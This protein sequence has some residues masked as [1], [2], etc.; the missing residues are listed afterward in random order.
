MQNT[1]LEFNKQAINLE[2]I[3]LQEEKLSKILNALR[4]NTNIFNSCEDYFEFINL[5]SNQNLDGYWDNPHEIRRT[6]TLE[7]LS[8]ACIIVIIQNQKLDES[9]TLHLKNILYN[10][11]QNFL[12]ILNLLLNRLDKKNFDSNV[13]AAKLKSEII[14][15]RVKIDSNDETFLTE[16]NKIITNQITKLIAKKFKGNEGDNI[17][18]YSVLIGILK[19]IDV[20]PVSTVKNILTNL[21]GSLHHF[22]MTNRG[23]VGNQPVQTPYLPPIENKTY[24]L[25]LDLDETLVH[26]VNVSIP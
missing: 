2:E 17:Q 15:K 26:Y 23:N 8:V 1:N 11:H 16:N 7:I 9:T 14:I 4:F 18:I 6:S 12:T 24:T 5:I 3:S 21:K 19:N 10:V 22:F 20:Y 13:W 25:V